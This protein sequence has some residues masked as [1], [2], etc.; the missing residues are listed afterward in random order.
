M[1][2]DEAMYGAVGIAHSSAARFYSPVLGVGT[3]G[4]EREKGTLIVA[5]KPV[6]TAKLI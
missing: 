2:L 3:E 1:K 4:S 5:V 6:K